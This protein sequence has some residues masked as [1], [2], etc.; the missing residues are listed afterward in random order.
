MGQDI[1]CHGS[2]LVIIPVQ[3]EPVWV[4][5]KVLITPSS[6]NEDILEREESL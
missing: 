4:R 3:K 2:G 5:Q 6:N 1:V